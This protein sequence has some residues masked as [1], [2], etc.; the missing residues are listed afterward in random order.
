MYS[1][2]TG[3]PIMQTG[4]AHGKARVE[5]R[6]VPLP[7]PR[8]KRLLMRK[9]RDRL[10]RDGHLGSGGTDVHLRGGRVCGTTPL[11]R[12]CGARGAHVAP[13]VVDE[14]LTARSRLRFPRLAESVFKRAPMG[15]ATRH[16]RLPALPG[17]HQ[18][19]V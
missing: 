5:R 2:L 8:P 1:A 6:P 7:H 10:L 14:G 9:K 16:R 17:F 4:A 12:R 19:S 11:Q 18:N 15:P 3:L 13:A